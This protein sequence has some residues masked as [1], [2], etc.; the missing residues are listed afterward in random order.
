MALTA[1]NLAS[2]SMVLPA[3]TS[4]VLASVYLVTMETVANIYV[5]VNGHLCNSPVDIAGA[6][7]V[8]V[9]VLKL[10]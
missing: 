1:W 6:L 5:Q 2:V 10:F 3:V 4:Q 7:P 8:Y 9:T